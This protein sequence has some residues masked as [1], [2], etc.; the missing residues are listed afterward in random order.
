EENNVDYNEPRAGEEY[1]IGSLSVD[2]VSPQE[3][4]DDLNDDSIVMHLTYGELK[5]MFSGDAE[6]NAEQLMVTSDNDL[7]A[8]ILKAGHQGCNT[9]SITDY[10]EEVDQ[11]ISIVSI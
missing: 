5:F 10:I 6:T 7:S 2:V 8:D 1:Q 9:S 4:T 11:N 3:V